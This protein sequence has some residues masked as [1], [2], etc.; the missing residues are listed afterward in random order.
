MKQRKNLSPGDNP[1]INWQKTTIL[2]ELRISREIS[3]TALAEAIG[4]SK[5]KMGDVERG[6]AYISPEQLEQIAVI[7]E[8]DVESISKGLKTKMTNKIVKGKS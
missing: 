1:F 4:V 5:T 8:T 2:R 7:L 3:S 6:I